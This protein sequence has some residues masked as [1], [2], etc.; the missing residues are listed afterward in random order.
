MHFPR[1]RQSPAELLQC[2]AHPELTPGV[3]LARSSRSNI[4]PFILNA[5][6]HPRKPLCLVAVHP[7]KP[8][9][10]N[11]NE[12]EGTNE[13]YVNVEK[14]FLP[15]NIWLPSWRRRCPSGGVSAIR[16]GSWSTCKD[17]SLTLR[18][19]RTQCHCLSFSGTGDFTVRTTGPSPTSKETVTAEGAG[20]Q[21]D[22]ND[23]ESLQ[24]VEPLIPK[25]WFEYANGIG[26]SL[27]A[28][29]TMLL[30]STPKKQTVV[31]LCVLGLYNYV[32]EITLS[33]VKAYL[34]HLL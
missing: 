9:R 5:R 1:L 10:K 14:I 24:R 4:T 28:K 3:T 22:F 7:G 19:A 32:S 2:P 21:E 31:L 34:D 13:F 16:R 15:T 25:N 18:S 26:V 27:F 20:G 11:M 12:E 8:K 17:A 29:S 33:D 23:L 6:M 30:V